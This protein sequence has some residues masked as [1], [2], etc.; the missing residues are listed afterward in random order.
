[1]SV[2]N[3]RTFCYNKR[4]PIAG[5]EP[6]GRHNKQGRS[7]PSP[8]SAEKWESSSDSVAKERSPPCQNSISLTRLS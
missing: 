4:I 5:Q 8:F 2:A 3:R 7:S 6:D 1:M